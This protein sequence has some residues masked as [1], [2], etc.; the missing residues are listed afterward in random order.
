MIGSQICDMYQP[1]GIK[2]PKAVGILGGSI[3]TIQ[4]SKW[5]AAF[6]NLRLWAHTAIADCFWIKKYSLSSVGIFLFSHLV[7]KALFSALQG[8]TS[9]FGRSGLRKAPLFGERTRD[10]AIR[11]RIAR[12]ALNERSPRERGV[13]PL[14]HQHQ[15]LIVTS[16]GSPSWAFP[17]TTRLTADCP[18]VWAMDKFANNGIS[19][20][21]FSYS[22]ILFLVKQLNFWQLFSWEQRGNCYSSPTTIVSIMSSFSVS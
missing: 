18:T 8:L 22:I 5:K 13:D 1:P 19:I 20:K 9:V 21:F 15:L 3:W 4:A 17:A 12:S 11:E 10:G 2:V 7:A 14:R 6:A 16:F